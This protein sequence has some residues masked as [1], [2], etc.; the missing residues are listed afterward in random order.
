MNDYNLGP[1]MESTI[2]KDYRRCTTKN[3]YEE[4]IE[5]YSEYPKHKYVGL[6]QKRIQE[7]LS[8]SEP[9]VSKVI[10]QTKIPEQTKSPITNPIGFIDRKKGI[11]VK[12]TM[13]VLLL[14]S[15][16]GLSYYKYSINQEEKDFH[17]LQLKAEQQLQH[18][19]VTLKKCKEINDHNQAIFDSKKKRIGKT[20]QGDQESADERER[21]YRR[22][23]EFETAA[24]QSSLSYQYA[25]EHYDKAYQ[26]Y[27][28]QDYSE[29]IRQAKYID[30]CHS[31]LLRIKNIIDNF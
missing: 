19:D 9:S 16:I 5:Q 30:D 21:R 1:R 15:V 31:N 7:I 4:F 14:A 8:P 25:E 2:E 10:S 29:V 17:S 23:I 26:K 3:D 28:D 11:A 20:I 6:A 18:A 24:F 13:Y 12:I 22:E 27:T